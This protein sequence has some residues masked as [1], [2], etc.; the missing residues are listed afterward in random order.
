MLL[1]HTLQCPRLQAS[2][3]LLGPQLSVHL[4]PF[5][6]LLQAPPLGSTTSDR[7]GPSLTLSHP[8]LFPSPAPMPFMSMCEA[9]SRATQDS[10]GQKRTAA[11]PYPALAHLGPQ[12]IGE[13]GL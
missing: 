9:R 6:S 10:N 2:P 13:L 12:P 11:F 7:G 8:R 5:W 4:G 3:S 1:P